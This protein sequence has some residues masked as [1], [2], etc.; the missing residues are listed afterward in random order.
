MHGVL[1]KSI[2]VLLVL[3]CVDLE[4]IHREQWDVVRAL[5]QRR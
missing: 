1:G 3:F 4:E 5:A 2:D